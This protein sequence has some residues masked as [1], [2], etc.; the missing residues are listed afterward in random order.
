MPELPEVETI[1]LG[2]KDRVINRVIRQVRLNRPEAVKNVGQKA[3]VSALTGNSFLGVARRGKYLAFPMK[4]GG[5]LVVHLGMTGRLLLLPYF[6][7]AEADL[8]LS[9]KEGPPLVYHD[10]RHLGRILLLKEEESDFGRVLGLGLEPLSRAFTVAWLK[11]KVGQTGRDIKTF[12]L[13]QKALAGIGNIYACEALFVAGIHPQT[14]CQELNK[15]KIND[16]KEG[17]IFVLKEALA[18]RGTSFSDYRDSNGQQGEYQN[19]LKVYGREGQNCF[20]CSESIQRIKQQGRSSYFC[21]GCQK[22]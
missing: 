21:P 15:R 14:R 1:R 16:L 22:F 2:L 13:D 11:S 18:K 17:V 6:P 10:K 8:V 9:F 20:R 4:G 5:T 7:L 12:L 3:F 19:F